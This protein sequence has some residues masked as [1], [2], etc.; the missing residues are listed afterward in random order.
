MKVKVLRSFIDKETKQPREVND[1]FDC[2]EARYEQI[3]T[4][5]HFVEPVPEK[6]KE[7]EVKTK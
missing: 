7:S 6:K 2:S 1:V 4:V 5:G 3:E